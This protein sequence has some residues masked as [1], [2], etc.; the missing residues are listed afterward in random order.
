MFDAE[1]YFLGHYLSG[2]AVECHLR[3]Y[4]RRNTSQFSSRH[5]IGE[6]AK[7]SGFY[8]IVPQKKTDE[9][10]EK[11]ITAFLSHME[12]TIE[13]GGTRYTLVFTGEHF[14]DGRRAD[15]VYILLNRWYWE[16]LNSVPT[17]PLDYD[18][19][20]SL[21]PAAQRFYEL[22][23]FHIYGV[24]KNNR[25]RARMLYS[26]FCTLAPQLRYFQYKRMHRQMGDVHAPHIASGYL[27]KVVEFRETTDR[28][29]NPDWEIFI[30]PAR[31]PEQTT[32]SR[33]NALSAARV[34]PGSY[35]YHFPRRSRPLPLCPRSMLSRLAPISKLAHRKPFSLIELASCPASPPPGHEPPQT[36]R[37][38]STSGNRE[39][40]PKH[41]RQAVAPQQEG[42]P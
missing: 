25:P 5:D 28:D 20:K 12:R 19:L 33:E 21:P 9:F 7:E 22:I 11:F 13:I 14:P 18:Y 2:L 37:Q 3:A 34:A 38:A 30:P 6:L 1:Q 42:Y 40:Q 24:L 36:V 15:A 23:S 39:R 32:A 29:G 8:E 26:D 27:E 4:I 16:I 10:S 41:R 35:C 17:R 31:R